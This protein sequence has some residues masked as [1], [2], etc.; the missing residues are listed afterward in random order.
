MTEYIFYNIVH[1]TYKLVEFTWVSV[2]LT[3]VVS[4]HLCNTA[5]SQNASRGCCFFTAQARE[6]NLVAN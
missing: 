3:G 2:V 5:E 6:T 4:W 1:I